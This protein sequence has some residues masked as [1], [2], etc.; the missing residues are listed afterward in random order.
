MPLEKNH[1]RLDQKEGR[2]KENHPTWASAA[3]VAFG[4][5]R[6][7]LGPHPAP[8]SPWRPRRHPHRSPSQ[9]ASGASAICNHCVESTPKQAPARRRPRRPPVRPPGDA[10]HSLFIPRVFG[11]TLIV[12][13]RHRLHASF[14]LCIISR[15]PGLLPCINICTL[16]I[17]IERSSPTTMERPNT[18]ILVMICQEGI[19]DT[20]N[21]NMV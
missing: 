8:G 4:I 13:M 9:P 17:L 6:V 16:K 5:S 1:H 15:K 11:G 18:P 19:S 7:S 2:F 3:G 21:L 10:L 14:R 12:D 20:P